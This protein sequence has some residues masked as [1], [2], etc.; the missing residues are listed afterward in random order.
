M[1]GTYCV[2]GGTYWVVGGLVAWVCGVVPPFEGE[3]C[4]EVAGGTVVAVVGGTVG[5][6]AGA[7]G[8]VPVNGRVVAPEAWPVKPERGECR[9]AA[10]EGETTDRGPSA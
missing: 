7:V 5:F 9:Q 4:G 1:G 2:V 8:S 3:V 6:V 10:G